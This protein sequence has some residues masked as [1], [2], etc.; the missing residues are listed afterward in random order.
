[1]AARACVLTGFGIN[2]DNETFTALE[3]AGAAPKKVH[4]NDLI[5]KKDSLENYEILAVPGGFSFGDDIASGKVFANKFKFNLKKDMMRFINDGK[6][7]IGICNGFQVMV[8]MG[9]LPALDGQYFNQ[10][11]TLTINDSGRFEDRWVCLKELKSDCVFT[12]G[13]G[14]I[15]LPVRH[16]EG[17]FFTDKKTLGRVMDEHLVTLK[18]INADGS[19]PKYPEN[20]NGSLEDIAAI[21][22]PSGHLFGLM[23]HPE[24]YLFKTNHPRWTREKVPPVGMGRRIFENAVK[25][26]KKK[27]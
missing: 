18:Y 22:D 27:F 17:K 20:P 9:I 23:P 4:I 26:C 21:C 6:I 8:K 19:R 5:H 1:M 7:S 14:K 25:Y 15:A 12:Q 3:L 16:G 2:C 10:Q 13:L 24:A 11:V